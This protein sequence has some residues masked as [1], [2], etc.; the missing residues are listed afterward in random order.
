M[1]KLLLITSLMLFIS[2]CNYNPKFK[3][4]FITI[5]VKVIDKLDASKYRIPSDLYYSVNIDFKNN[6]D[7]IIQFWMMTCSWQ[8][9]WIFQSDSI[10]LYGEKCTTNY[11][12]L[13]NIN[14]REIKI[15]K[16]IIC[17]KDSKKLTE[18]NILKIGFVLVKENELSEDI[19][20]MK[21]LRYKIK[22]QKDI[23]W[24]E[25]FKLDK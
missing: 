11:P 20:F 17:V 15:F 8:N 22:C 4:S 2:Q 1:K 24:S 5:H 19:D 12:L 25:P 13:H 9:N 6:T 10:F 7:S 16:S 18:G 21:L 23:I 3:E 14:P